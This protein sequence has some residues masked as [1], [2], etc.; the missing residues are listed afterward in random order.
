V[1]PEYSTYEIAERCADGNG[2]VEDAEDAVAVHFRV[3]VGEQRGSVDT[4]CCFAD[5][6]DGVADE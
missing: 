3:E 1:L 2:D 6:D 5:A 4:E